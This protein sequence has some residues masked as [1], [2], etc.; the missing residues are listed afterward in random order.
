MVDRNEK[1]RMHAVGAGGAL[2]Q[3]SPRRGRGDQQ[4]GLRKAGIVQGLIDLASELEVEGIFRDAARAHCAGYIDSV[5]DIDHN[6]ERR[7]RATLGLCR[8]GAGALLTAHALHS[9][10]QKRESKN[11]A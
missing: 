5:T 2:E 10:R 4:H 9:R 8:L 7:T 6:A 1:I 11:S 3:A